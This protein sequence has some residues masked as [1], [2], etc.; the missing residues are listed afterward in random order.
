MLAKLEV[1]GREIGKPVRIRH[2][3][4]TVRVT[5]G[6]LSHWQTGREGA[7]G[8]RP[9]VRIPTPSAGA[10]SCEGQGRGGVFG[11]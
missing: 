3:P 9:Q 7:P 8:G 5:K 6:A 4:A 11:P 10:S 1:S 2:S